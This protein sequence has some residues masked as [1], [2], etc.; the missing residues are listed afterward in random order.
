MPTDRT[1]L[2]DFT[3]IVSTHERDNQLLTVHC[4]NGD[5][6]S[7]YVKSH[8]NDHIRLEYEGTWYFIVLNAVVALE[9]YV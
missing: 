3:D 7:G 1:I 2:T 8:N 9:Y 4:V 5:S 6:Y